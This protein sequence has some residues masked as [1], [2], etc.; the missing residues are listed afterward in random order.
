[1]KTEAADDCRSTKPIFFALSFGSV[2]S[3]VVM[4]VLRY[5]GFLY[6][7]IHKNTEV[8][9]SFPLI[10]TCSQQVS[11]GFD[12]SLGHTQAHTTFGRTPLDK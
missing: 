12:F 9:S 3:K 10:P 4:S 11:R 6:L 7:I 1:V 8:S 2:I 5:E